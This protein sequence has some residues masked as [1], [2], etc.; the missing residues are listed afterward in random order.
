MLFYKGLH[1][2]SGGCIKRLLAWPLAPAPSAHCLGLVLALELDVVQHALQL[3]P[4]LVQLL[5]T[6]LGVLLL[7]LRLLQGAI[8]PVKVCLHLLGKGAKQ[9]QT[10]RV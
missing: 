6:F 8:L 2:C 10:N 3:R 4:L 5:Q 9:N 1:S 7:G